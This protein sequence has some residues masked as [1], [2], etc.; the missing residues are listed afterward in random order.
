[1]RVASAL[2]VAVLIGSAVEG[3]QVKLDV[4]MA[5]PYLVADKKQ[6][7]YMK[8]G[9]TGFE[10]EDVAKRT[11]VN[12]AIVL[13][14]SSSMSGE[15]MEKAKQAAIMAVDRLGEDDIVSVIAYNHGVSVLVP[16]T[17][18]THRG[19][20]QDGIRKL[21]AT[22]TT[23]LFA[24]VSKGAAE[25][26][27]FLDRNRVNRVIL[28]SDGLANVGPQTPGELG[29]LGSALIKQG[30]SVSTIGLGDGYNEDLMAELAL[31]SDGNHAF[32]QT[33]AQLA[34]IF[35]YEFGDV[36]SVVAQEV[37][38]TI[39]CE[40]GIR[41]VRVLGR[42]ADISGQ[43]VVATLNQLYSRQE[44]FVLLEV[45]TPPRPHNDVLDIGKVE[46]TYANMETKTTDELTSAV[47]VRFTKSE[48]EVALQV[49][50][51]VMV[52]CVGLIAADRNKRALALRDQGDVEAARRMLIS[53]GEYLSV[54]ASS[55]ESP[56]LDQQAG[57]NND[58]AINLDAG[59]WKIQRKKMRAY[60]YEMDNQLM[61]SSR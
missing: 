28:L 54:N 12:I 47:A 36:L 52:S 50:R 51:L 44:K 26:R 3:R 53:N 48:E 60:Q 6:V 27:K 11:P 39:D 55:L 61:N 18:A 45:E 19:N 7:T 5:N 38:V 9:L 29:E 24:G 2:T 20:I 32:A 56:D 46:I 22:G 30:I 42:K 58:D 17:K 4:A 37:V 49:D 35:N 34:K 21:R 16:A 57:W 14:R 10:F 15:K 59:K 13:D 40:P 31:R 25:I 33:P 1:M 41:P 43:R 23:A 8:I